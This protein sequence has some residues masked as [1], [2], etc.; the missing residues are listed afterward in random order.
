[1]VSSKGSCEEA[2]RIPTS[3]AEF[4]PYGELK[5]Y[6]NDQRSLL[7][8]STY[9]F[10]IETPRPGARLL[11]RGDEQLL[12]LAAE[13]EYS[14]FISIQSLH[15]GKLTSPSSRFSPSTICSSTNFSGPGRQIKRDPPILNRKHWNLSTV[16]SRSSVHLIATFKL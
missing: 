11:Q 13:R 8:A 6:Y 15:L 5:Q 9:R 3:H 4:M 2:M 14:S 7:F 10:C 12:Q 1:M 16:L